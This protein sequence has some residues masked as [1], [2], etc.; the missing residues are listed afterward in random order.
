LRQFKAGLAIES[1]PL[2]L[3][4]G[5]SWELSV[6]DEFPSRTEAGELLATVLA[7]DPLGMLGAESRHGRT[8]T[9]LLVKWL[10]AEDDLSL[11]IHPSDDYKGLARGEA[12]KLET[13]YIV[14]A[15]PGAGIYFGFHP[16]V[17]AERVRDA[18]THGADL[19][20]LM[21]FIEVQPG[22]FVMVESGTPHAVGKGV[23]LLEPQ[24]TAPGCSGVTYR[25]WDFGRRYDASGRRDPNGQPRALHVE[26]ALAVT[27][28]ERACDETWLASRR[29]AGG[30]PP[31]SES[32][33]CELLCGPDTHAA[34]PSSRLR[35]A[36]AWGTGAVR[37]PAWHALR[38]VTVIA[39]ELRLGDGA[40]E[41]L[42]A[43]GST[44]VVPAALGGLETQ[45]RNAHVLIAAAA[46]PAPATRGAA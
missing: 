5:E 4:V 36:R 15:Q 45:L 33:R 46:A 8:L 40:N 23:T 26:H 2:E 11:Q 29:V 37:L 7:R 25:Y 42:V 39:G 10:D 24:I 30:W 43:A 21:R 18:L 6:S 31:A 38:A 16:G 1:T 44:A 9:S 28:W 20:E 22:D 17:N 12:G 34:L 41:V 19:R 32:A 3:P 13:W 14:A 27:R 35:V